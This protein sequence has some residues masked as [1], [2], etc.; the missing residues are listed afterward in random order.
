MDKSYG[1]TE[2]LV[3]RLLDRGHRVA[4]RTAGLASDFSQSRAEVRASLEA[5]GMI[6]AVPDELLVQIP[7]PSVCATDGALIC[8]SRAIG[9]ICTAVGVAFG[10]SEVP[11]NEI[12][13]D[14]VPRSARNKEILTGVMA[15]MEIML[16]ATSD[17]ELVM[18]DGSLLGAMINISKAVTNSRSRSTALEERAMELV[19]PEMRD[20]VMEI[21]MSRRFVAVPK[22]T[23]T[24]AEFDGFLPAAINDFDGRTVATMAL[25]AGEM[26]ALFNA[27]TSDTASFEK[28]NRGMANV[29]GFSDKD[30]DIFVK[31]LRSVVYSYYRPHAWTPAFRFDVPHELYKDDD[32]GRRVLK[33]LHESTMSPGIREPLPLFLVDRFAKQISVGASPVMDMAA[34]EY[35]GDDEA[36]LLMIMGYRT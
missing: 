23:T 19:G 24:N 4:V 25:G 8:D 21:L 36:L 29:F 10:P 16:A 34:L 2:D 27:D 7:A 3:S 12:W 35:S 13:M 26:M 28:K 18:I 30:Y 17:A 9:D 14:C 22:Y 1:S 15:G 33:A 6:H 32:A 5:A 31:A 20:A 11:R